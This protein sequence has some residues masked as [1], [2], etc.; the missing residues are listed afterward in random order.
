MLQ[1]IKSIMKSVIS[2]EGAMNKLNLVMNP[3]TLSKE[4]IKDIQTLAMELLVFNLIE[5]ETLNS[6]SQKVRDKPFKE[7]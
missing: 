4:E 6:I 2:L 3:S 5:G 1:Y 7:A